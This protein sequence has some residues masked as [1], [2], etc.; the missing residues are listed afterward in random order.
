MYQKNVIILCFSCLIP[1]VVAVL[2]GFLR[3]LL[4]VFAVNFLSLVDDAAVLS[5]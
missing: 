3:C 4:L 2:G 1:L 5:P